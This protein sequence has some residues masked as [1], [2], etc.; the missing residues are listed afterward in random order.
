M[1]K[2]NIFSQSRIVSLIS[3]DMSLDEEA[4]LCLIK[5]NIPFLRDCAFDVMADDC[6]NRVSKN[7]LLTFPLEYL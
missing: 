6:I 7:F 2:L 3:L 5:S 1:K 4:A